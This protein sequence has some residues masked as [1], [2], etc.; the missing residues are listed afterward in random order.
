MLEFKTVNYINIIVFQCVEKQNIMLKK[1]PID[2][3][4]G[5]LASLK[6]AILCLKGYNEVQH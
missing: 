6:F 3:P 1:K 2:L 4:N 5:F